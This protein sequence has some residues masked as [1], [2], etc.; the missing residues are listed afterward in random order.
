VPVRRTIACLALAALLYAAAYSPFV[1][2]HTDEDGEAPLVHAH[3]PDAEI[4]HAGEPSHIEPLHGSHHR[5]RSIDI[6]TTTATPDIALLAVIPATYGALT[7]PAP[8]CGF[9]SVAA[10]RAH[11]PPGLPSRIPRAPPA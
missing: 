8:C 7:A 5:A 2:V 6:F 1:H 10:P 4:G 9:V 3:F 11:A